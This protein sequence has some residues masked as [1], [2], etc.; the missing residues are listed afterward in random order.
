MPTVIDNIEIKLLDQLNHFIN[1]AT[2]VK[3]CIGY[4]NVK[5][6]SAL[7]GLIN[8]LP[9]N[10]SD[11]PCRVLLGM[12]QPKIG[13]DPALMKSSP[14]DGEHLRAAL[15]SVIDDV[16]AQITWG[17]PTKSAQ[18]ALRL[19]ATQIRDRVVRIKV[20][21]CHPLHAKL[22]L[23][24]R[25]DHITPLIGYV[26]SSNLTYAGL[27]EQGELNVDVVEQ[28][29]AGKLEK[30]F[31]RL[32]SDP[33]A[34]DISDQLAKAIDAS[35]AG[36]KTEETG[37][38]PYL[39]YLK[40]A[41]HLS[42]DARLGVREFK[43]PADLHGALLDYQLAAVQTAARL[44]QRHGGVLLGDVVGL[45]KTLM[46]TA[47]ARLLHE[48]EP[49]STLVICPPKLQ[50]MWERYLDEY[51][52]KVG[53]DARTLSL[54]KVQD[55]LP[56]LR[57]YGTL[58][59]DESHNLTN[60]KSKRYQAIEGYIQAN[61]P[62]VILL[63]ATPYNKRF[64][65]LG[66]Q[67]RLFLDEQKELPSYPQR[68]IDERKAQGED[69]RALAARL[70]A[71]L[72]SLRCF[73]KSEYAED[74]RDLMRHY[75][76]R[77]TRSF[78]IRN[79]AQFDEAEQRYFVLTPDGKR[80]YF[81][82]R[83][84][85]T[86]KV[87]LGKT[88]YDRLYSDDA[89]A[90]INQLTLARYGLAAYLD[91]GKLAGAPKELAAIADDLSRAGE[92]LI[93]FARTS[94]FKRLE[95]SGRA[96]LLSVE[97]Q[98]LRNAVVLHALAQSELLP[99]GVQDIARFDP[100]AQ[101]TD[102]EFEGEDGNGQDPTER[103][104]DMV[105]SPEAIVQALQQR[106]AE[107][108]RVLREEF[109]DRF[110]W[111]PAQYFD[112]E[113][114]RRDLE[115]DNA[116]FAQL[117]HLARGWRDDDDPKFARLLELVQRE[118][119][120]DKV[121]VFT[122]FVDTAEALGRY[123]RRQGVLA[124]GVVTSQTDD[125]SALARRFS[126]KSNGGLRKGEEE[127][128]VL[129]ATDTLSE[130]QNLQD[131]HIVVNFDLPWAI[132]RLIQRAG[133]V[134]RIGQTHPTITVYSFL[135]AEGIER[136]IRLRQLLS[137]RL[138]ENQAVI[139]TDEVFFDE[140]AAKALED[141]YTE[142]AHVLNDAVKDDEVD[143]TSRALEVW[144]S[145]SEEMRQR[146]LALPPQVYVTRANDTGGPDGAVVFARLIRGDERD[147]RLIRVDTS[148]KRLEHSLA[149]AFEAM[150]CAPETPAL[151]NPDVLDLVYHASQLI[152]G[153]V[154]EGGL[155]GALGGSRSLRA[156]L[157]KRLRAIADAP[158]ARGNGRKGNADVRNR[159]KALADRLFQFALNRGVEGRLRMALQTN[160]DDAELVGLLAALDD[161][162]ELVVVSQP[163]E[164]RVEILCT[165]GLK[166]LERNIT[167]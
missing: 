86:V 38:L 100:A 154:R 163:S 138:Q 37:N 47:L 162:G 82:E 147:D 16:K 69:E 118:H 156:R 51:L 144:E 40:V 49:R 98:I 70:Q 151:S 116:R 12:I 50:A 21:L 112:H 146:A 78:I 139:G 23:L 134:D 36:K 14:P 110:R 56:T 88:L 11:P 30:W 91:K 43:L 145:A 72:N 96:F 34:V 158:P 44:V 68:Y 92:R 13:L 54:G 107:A 41:Y 132:V 33:C 61:D 122:Q 133:R 55:E 148:G 71:S 73:D 63:T 65:D 103:V 81:P 52:R 136:I 6:W 18:E 142:K 83:Q 25:K 75:M 104:E 26:G 166:T 161:A 20:Y 39:A 115:A 19:L 28:D 7:G 106:A 155:A 141:L 32:W 3:I 79:Y 15:G 90:L 93:G 152:E 119:G 58:I 143:L 53:A 87:P 130:G 8:S 117:L 126:P 95:S 140:Q 109:A 80:F 164:T 76:V 4:L 159:A 60:R 89:V 165:M 102:E 150:R 167:P 9:R 129:I 27:Y 125:P 59:L 29:A 121:L 22:Y 5:G 153:E 67:L 84:P 74:W 135:P 137:H 127:L 114:L 48:V 128:R 35:W 17:V 66:S 1:Q 99:I 149:A 120:A 124:L 77:R 105:G 10:P 113:A 62:K 85:R 24:R 31:D 45:G 97:R 108:Y 131:C 160:V 2:Q 101:D 46:A 42:E 94:L 57:R 64:T 123:L 111:M 157:Y